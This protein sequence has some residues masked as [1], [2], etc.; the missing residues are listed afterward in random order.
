MPDMTPWSPDAFLLV[1]VFSLFMAVVGTLTGKTVGRIGRV[2]YRTK[3]P[4][5]FWEAIGTYYVIG[6]C[7]IG[8]FTYKVYGPSH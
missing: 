1:G 4:K 6:L 8:Y 2:I 5:V 3:E 7:F